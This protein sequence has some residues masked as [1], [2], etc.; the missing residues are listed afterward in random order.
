MIYSGLELFMPEGTPEVEIY[1][2]YNRQNSLWYSREETRYSSEHH[3]AYKTQFL[4]TYWFVS[5]P[6][7]L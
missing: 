4:K 2:I 3:R 6:M 1:Q 5:D 7:T